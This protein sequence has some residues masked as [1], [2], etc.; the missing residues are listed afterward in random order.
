MLF[1][2]FNAG[3]QYSK[4]VPQLREWVKRRQDTHELY[5]KMVQIFDGYNHPK[6]SPNAKYY[7]AWSRQVAR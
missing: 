6:S 2:I 5:K 4:A 1:K 3:D 7:K